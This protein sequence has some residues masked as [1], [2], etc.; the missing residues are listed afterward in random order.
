MLTVSR[1]D[2]AG[3]E[4]NMGLASWLGRI[5]GK[6]AALV[7]MLRKAGCVLYT[8]MDRVF[9]QRDQETLTYSARNQYTHD[10]LVG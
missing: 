4:N 3:K 9:H 5:S 2:V 8:R 10:S 7:T 1:F 6:D